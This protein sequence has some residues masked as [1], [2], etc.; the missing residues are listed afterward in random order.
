MTHKELA[1]RG[2]SIKRKDKNH[3][4]RGKIL[5]FEKDFKNS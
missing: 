2:F 3:I 1:Q 4:K 5:S